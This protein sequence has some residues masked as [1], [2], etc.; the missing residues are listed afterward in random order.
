MGNIAITIRILE[1]HSIAILLSRLISIPEEVVELLTLSLDMAQLFL[2]VSVEALVHLFRVWFEFVY[3]LLFVSF[4]SY[5][6]DSM[7]CYRSLQ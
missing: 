1:E 3:S 7:L 4:G 5:L 6:L 2:T